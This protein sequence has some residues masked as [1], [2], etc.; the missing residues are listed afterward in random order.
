M[1]SRY[2]ITFTGLVLASGAGVFLGTVPVGYL[3][4]IATAFV[5]TPTLLAL[6][7]A[8]GLGALV[9][10][11]VARGTRRRVRPRMTHRYRRFTIAG[12][13]TMP[14]LLFVGRFPNLTTNVTASEWAAGFVVCSGL[15]GMVVYYRWRK[16]VALERH[17]RLA[18]ERPEQSRVAV[19]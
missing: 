5:D 15:A 1:N 7:G 18:S 10:L 16:R 12:L 3:A 19:R 9:G 8:L 2:G 14:G 17:A 11:V 4:L 13:A 6:P